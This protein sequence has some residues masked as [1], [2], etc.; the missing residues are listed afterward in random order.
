MNKKEHE[1]LQ[2]KIN[3]LT[4]NDHESLKDILSEILKELAEHNHPYRPPPRLK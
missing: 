1:E 2:E 4:P 3:M